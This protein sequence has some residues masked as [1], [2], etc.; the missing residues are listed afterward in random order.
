MVVCLAALS[1][2]G[3]TKT[4]I[5]PCPRTK[6]YTATD[7]MVYKTQYNAEL[8]ETFGIRYTAL[9]LMVTKNQY[10]F[11]RLDDLEERCWVHRSKIK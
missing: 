3:P 1:C 4:P 10:V 5:S 2:L 8:I 11:D 6:Y 7:S 9:G